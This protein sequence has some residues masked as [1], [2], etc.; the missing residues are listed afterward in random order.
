[1]IG[2]SGIDQDVQAKMDAYRGNPR[3][4]E[5]KYAQ[6]KQ[7][8]DLLA[9]QQLKSEKEAAVREMQMKMGG[10][11]TPTVGDKLEGEV[12]DLTK[13]ELAQNTTGAMQ[14]QQAQQQQAAKQMVQEQA[15]QAAPMMQGVAGLQAP[16]M[17]PKAMAAGGIVAFQSGGEPEYEEFQQL[18]ERLRPQ[19]PAR[20]SGESLAQRGIRT[21]IGDRTPQEVFTERERMAREAANYTPEERATMERQLAEKKAMDEA[22]YNIDRR[23]SEGL[24]R[25]L[26]GAGG[27]TGIGSVLGGAGASAVNY[28]EAMD[29]QERNALVD[30]QKQEAGLVNVGPASRAAGMKYGTESEKNAIYG[31]AQG[32]GDAVK[33]EQIQAAAARAG[34]S[35]D[36]KRITQ[37]YQALNNNPEI[38]ALLKTRES[39]TLPIDAPENQL[40]NRRIYEIAAPIFRGRN[41]DPDLFIPKPPEVN[42]PP[43]KPS[44]FEGLGNFI[45][46]TLGL[47]PATAP[48]A[49]AIDFSQLQRRNQQP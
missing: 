33:L 19:A 9:L 26:L 35:P 14:Q 1:M 27:R 38:R 22:R 10:Q 15:K 17:S 29:A 21:L 46:G 42:E 48:A 49:R 45:Q 5:Q 16:N 13:Q 24:T 31:L 32:T 3:G 23:R 34:V 25:W 28:R 30:R 4:L 6:N 39:S 2:N 11:Q 43:P 20:P 18:E 47:N 44:R 7:L 8:I 36:D 37:A 12:L 41:L 40:I